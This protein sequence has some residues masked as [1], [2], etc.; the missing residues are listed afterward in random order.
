MPGDPD[1]IYLSFKAEEEESRLHGRN[2]D[3]GAKY[4]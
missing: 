3:R 1:M 2:P 4:A